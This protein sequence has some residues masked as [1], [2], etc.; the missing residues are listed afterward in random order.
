[1]IDHN[2]IRR[3]EF[4]YHKLSS[5]EEKELQTV[6][7]A[8]KHNIL[9]AAKINQNIKGEHVPLAIYAAIE[10]M[11]D[12]LNGASNPGDNTCEAVAEIKHALLSAFDP[13]ETPEIA[14]ILQKTYNI[15]DS[16]WLEWYYRQ[17]IRCLIHMLYAAE[18]WNGDT[19]IK[20]G[21]LSFLRST[22]GKAVPDSDTSYLF[23]Q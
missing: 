5:A 8:L 9:I 22:I 21:Y 3:L 23:L 11:E 13:F 19:H 14:N 15:Y 20:N 17:P 1:M 6:F 7:Y 18:L 10:Q 12:R 2:K 4:K 16:A